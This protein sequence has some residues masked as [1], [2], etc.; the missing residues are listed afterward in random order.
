M[1]VT[2]R[3]FVAAIITAGTATGISAMAFAADESGANAQEDGDDKAVYVIA[4]VTVKKDKRDELIRIFKGI[5]P[6]VHAE[7]GCLYYE[8]AV[9][10][11]SGI[12]A[13]DPLRPDVMVVVEKW[14]SLKCLIVHLDAPHMHTYREAVKDIVAGVTLQVLRQA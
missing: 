10:V 6:D 7:D 4:T 12:P 1:S 5:V 14:E 11:D 2:R 13:Q 9:D 3:D 8:P